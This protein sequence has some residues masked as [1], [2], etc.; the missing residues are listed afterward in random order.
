MMCRDDHLIQLQGST[1]NAKRVT[2]INGH[3]I[4]P[5]EIHCETLVIPEGTILKV[6]KVQIPVTGYIPNAWGGGVSVGGTIG[7]SYPSAWSTTGMIL[8]SG[9]FLTPA[10]TTTAYYVNTDGDVTG[11]IGAGI[12][13]YMEGAVYAT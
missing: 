4:G 11:T 2:L 5:C 7:Q 13:P 1:D 10:P 8:A 12:T 6:E 9:A 3:I